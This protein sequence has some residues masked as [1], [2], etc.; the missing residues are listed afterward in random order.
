MTIKIMPGDPFCKGG[1]DVFDEAIKVV[2]TIQELKPATYAHAGWITS[3]QGD[4]L[5]ELW[6][7]QAGHINKYA[8]QPVLV[9]RWNGM[10]PE[11][12]TKAIN[13]VRALIGTPYPIERLFDFFIPG[14]PE[15]LGS[16]EEAVCSERTA[17]ELKDA[18]D[19]DIKNWKGITPQALADLMLKSKNF[20]V[21]YQGIWDPGFL[22]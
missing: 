22:A 10:T 13:Q 20:T 5:E 4:T 8:G 2:E 1:D 14:G 16:K 7:F 18:G 6:R 15:A 21:I 19:P 3:S 12:F 11:S 17:E 9:C